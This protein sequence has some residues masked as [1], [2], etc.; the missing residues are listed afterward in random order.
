MP[1]TGFPVR[2]ICKNEAKE[3]KGKLLSLVVIDQAEPGVS[4]I[5]SKLQ[6]WHEMCQ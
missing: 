2:K 4:V 3:H 5:S 1:D 6:K